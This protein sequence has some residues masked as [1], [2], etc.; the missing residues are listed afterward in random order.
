ME[1]EKTLLELAMEDVQEKTT[2]V[3]A[4][5][6]NVGTVRAEADRARKAAIRGAHEKLTAAKSAL[7]ES[8]KAFD[9]AINAAQKP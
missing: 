5:K 7:A 2:A 8:R 4:A 1:T 3:A 9:R 6:A